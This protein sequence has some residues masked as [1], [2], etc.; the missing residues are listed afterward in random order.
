M[1]IVVK[2]RRK[3]LSRDVP[4]RENPEIRMWTITAKPGS[5]IEA[6]E[7]A[8]TGAIAAVDLAESQGR[9]LAADKRFTEEGARDQFRKHVLRD[10]VPAFHRGRMTI[11]RARQE[12]DQKRA[13]LQLPKGEPTDAAAAIRR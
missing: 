11:S 12:L 9:Q 6:L 13:M 7:Q 3:I 2:G 5:T 4:G 10:S 8:Y 1:T